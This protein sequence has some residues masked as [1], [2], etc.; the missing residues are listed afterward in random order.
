MVKKKVVKKKEKIA[1]PIKWHVPENTITRYATNMIAQVLENEVKLSFFEL[2][3]DIRLDPKEPHQK[4]VQANCVASVI[5]SVTKLP[6]IID[7]LQQ[8]FDHFMKTRMPEEEL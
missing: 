7:V 8:Q 1:I 3:P 5:V 4:E 2:S 6:Q